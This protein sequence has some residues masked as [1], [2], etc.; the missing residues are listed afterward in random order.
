MSAKKIQQSIEEQVLFSTW[1]NQIKHA[2]DT[3]SFDIAD[4][5]DDGSFG[6]SITR[7]LK[8]QEEGKPFPRFDNL[9]P[10][11]KLCD[12]FMAG[13]VD[14]DL[15]EK[16]SSRG[17][18]DVQALAPFYK[19]LL[20]KDTGGGFGMPMVLFYASY[21]SSLAEYIRANVDQNGKVIGVEPEVRESLQGLVARRVSRLALGGSPAI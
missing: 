8:I 20:D 21:P 2:R 4:L 3:I 13:K 11:I 9:E 6:P 15:L 18:Q 1:Y 17:K 10:A 12:Q 19:G 14:I 5:K 16:V 7:I